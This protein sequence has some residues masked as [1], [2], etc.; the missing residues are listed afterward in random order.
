VPLEEAKQQ[1]ASVRRLGKLIARVKE[2]E[3]KLG[4]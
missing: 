2:I 4:L 3:K 1:I